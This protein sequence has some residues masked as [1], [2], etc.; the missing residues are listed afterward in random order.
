[1]SVS[2]IKNTEPK[3]VNIP[4]AAAAG[5]GAGIA[6]RQIIP[7]LKPEIDMVLFGES[8]VI[9]Q[10]NI[11]HARKNAIDE[12]VKMFSKDKDNEALKLFLDRT[13]ASI[14]Y[15][16]AQEIQ[17][18]NAKIEAVKMAKAAKEKI[19]AAPESIQ[20]EIQS[21]TQKVINKVRAARKLTEVNLKTS[22]KQMRPYAPFILPGIAL[23]AVSAYIY[24]V[25]GT[26]SK[27]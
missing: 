9:R 19:K 23:G 22:V 6:A 24:N 13:K 1:M 27:D 21:L 26:I 15:E 10:N 12:V 2:V 8:D 4:L 20:K 14:K 25:I 7:V 18:A 3:N 11:K 17:S 16:N 5:A